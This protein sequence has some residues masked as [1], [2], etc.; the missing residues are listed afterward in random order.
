MTCII[1]HGNPMST[2]ALDMV[3]LPFKHIIR[4]V[5]LRIAMGCLSQILEHGENTLLPT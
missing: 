5:M 3:C 2:H 4:T 1:G